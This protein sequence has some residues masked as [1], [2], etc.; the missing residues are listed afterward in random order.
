MKLSIS[1]VP[2]AA[3]NQRTPSALDQRLCLLK[4]CK[5]V[6]PPAAIGVE[7]CVRS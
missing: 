1:T 6:L 3:T 4:N 7:E 2:L 5:M